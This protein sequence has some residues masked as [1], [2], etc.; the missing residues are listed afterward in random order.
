MGKV[1][2]CDMWAKNNIYIYIYMGWVRER[3]RHLENGFRVTW[4][5][6]G[7]DTCEEWGR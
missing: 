2:V 1:A 4:G 3:R 6:T 5:N 7:S